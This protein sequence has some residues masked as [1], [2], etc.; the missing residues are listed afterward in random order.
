MKVKR[1]YLGF[2]LKKVHG[3][4]VYTIDKPQQTFGANAE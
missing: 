2:V 1:Q 3:C 4:R